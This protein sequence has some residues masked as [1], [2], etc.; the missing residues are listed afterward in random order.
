MWMR[1]G[2]G[3]AGGQLEL[4]TDGFTKTVIGPAP[5]LI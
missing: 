2:D 4:L 1:K 5:S 3:D